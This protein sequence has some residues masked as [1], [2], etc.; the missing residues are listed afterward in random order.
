MATTLLPRSRSL[1]AL[2]AIEN[3]TLVNDRAEHVYDAWPTPVTIVSDGA[4]GVGGFHGDPRT[5]E[6]LVEWYTPHVQAWSRR[7]HPSTTLW[8]WNT[9]VGW[10][11][12]HPLLAGHGWQY[13]FANVW[14]KGIAHVAGNVNG[15]TIRRFPVVSEVCVFYSRKL[16]VHTPE[17]SMGVREWMRYEWTRTGLPFRLANA[18]CGVKDA[19][20]RK[21]FATDWLWYFPPADMMERLVTFAN[22]HG[23]PSGRPYYSIN[24]LGPVTGDEWARLRYKWNHK[25]GVTNVWQCPPLNGKERIRGTGVR[26]APRVYR[27]TV[28]S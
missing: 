19:A 21:Y 2:G 4:Y 3:F 24:G 6:G 17:G 10:A 28:Q 12:V 5:P 9:E 16:V 18:A 27:P 13:E 23:E 1:L 8:F 22:E 14:D 26:S 11:T 25:H 20:T 15:N 7:A